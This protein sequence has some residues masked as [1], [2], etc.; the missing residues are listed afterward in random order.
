MASVQRM[1][2]AAVF[3]VTFAIVKANQCSSGGECPGGN[4][5][6]NVVSMLQAKLQTS[7]LKDETKTGG[8]GSGTNPH[9]LS[10]LSTGMRQSSQPDDLGVTF[11]TITDPFFKTNLGASSLWKQRD[12]LPHEWIVIKNDKNAGISELYA[13]AQRE[14]QHPLL[15]FLHPDVMLP[16]DWYTNFRS[17]LAQLEAVDPNWGVLGTAGVALDWTPQKAVEVKIASSI[18]DLGGT[19][20]SG[21]DNLPVQSLDEH[22]LVLRAGSPKFDPNL[23]GFDF[24][25]TD[26]VL[27]SWKAGLKSYLLNLNVK[28]KTVDPEGKPFNLKVWLVKFNDAGYRKR[29]HVTK[30]YMH[31]KWDT[32][33]FLP[34]FGTA[35]DLFSN[36]FVSAALEPKAGVV[37][38]AWSNGVT[39]NACPQGSQVVADA[40][41]CK[42]LSDANG[43]NYLSNGSW[44]GRPIGCHRFMPYQYTYFNSHPTGRGHPNLALMCQGP[45]GEKPEKLVG[46]PGEGAEASGGTEGTSGEK[47]EKPGGKPVK[48]DGTSGG[49]EAR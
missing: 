26:I 33:K 12:T 43:L 25:G 40:A 41:S 37:Y 36:F 18:T 7:S 17:K 27:S 19:Y 39:D 11:I 13:K 35:F 16:D 31:N 9:T 32:S 2:V 29:A 44:S 15:V 48:A 23:P 46:E 45:P 5:P 10:I 20:A 1:V 28:H 3:M 4:E 30:A 8:D 24:Y 49:S 21:S 47:S 22:L 38:G 6:N 34:V 42:A 14:A